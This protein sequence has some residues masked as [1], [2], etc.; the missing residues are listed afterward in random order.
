[1]SG[2]PIV[3]RL[4]IAVCLMTAVCYWFFSGRRVSE[5]GEHAGKVIAAS[6]QC[7]FDENRLP[8]V[9]SYGL[10][11]PRGVTFDAAKKRVVMADGPRRRLVSYS[12]AGKG[13][14]EFGDLKSMSKSYCP[15]GS[16]ETVDLR[17]V[18]VLGGNFFIAEHNR[19][20]VAEVEP[21]ALASDNVSAIRTAAVMEGVSGIAFGAGTTGTFA[22]VASAAAKTR[23]SGNGQDATPRNAD[24]R[25]KTGALYG[26]EPLACDKWP[27]DF[28]QLT[29]IAAEIAHPSGV[30]VSSDG[31]LYVTEST[32]NETRWLQFKTKAAAPQAWQRSGV[33]AT[34]KSE[35]AAVPEFQ[36]IAL[37]KSGRL[38]YAAGPAGLYAFNNSGAAVGRIEFLGPVTGVAWGTDAHGESCLY[39]AVAHSLTR[40]RLNGNGD[41]PAE[42]DVNTAAACRAGG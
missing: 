41:A 32:R 25:N 16:P 17:G 35:G 2:R 23:E 39:V 14:E 42:S 15:E 5:A 24:Q 29:V 33:L 26:S 3:V 40:V 31:T 11:D 38:I 1:M 28:G 4:I 6:D 18:A 12:I 36:G 30:A 22:V 34:V 21:S 27:I 19:A 8:E 37:G 13:Y 7:P 10:E 20:R 9:L